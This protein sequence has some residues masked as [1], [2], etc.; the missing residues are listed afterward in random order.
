MVCYQIRVVGKVQGV[1]YRASTKTVA[2]E[3]GVKGWVKNELD[4]S[5][6][7]EAEGTKDKLIDLM[8]W[9]KKGP[10]HA[11]VDSIERTEVDLKHHN[12]FLIRH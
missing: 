12:V 3:L 7:I 8:A 4:G 9:C 6:L 1:F 10:L 2:D 11:K 5:V